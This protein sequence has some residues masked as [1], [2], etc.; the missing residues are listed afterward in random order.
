MRRVTTS[1]G[2]ARWVMTRTQH[3]GQRPA[4]AQSLHHASITRRHNM[5][6]KRNY[7]KH[8]SPSFDSLHEAV[9]S[10]NTMIMYISMF[11]LSARRAPW[12]QCASLHTYVLRAR[13]SGLLMR[14]G[15]EWLEGPPWGSTRQ[16]TH[17]TAKFRKLRDELQRNYDER[18]SGNKNIVLSFHVSVE[19][20]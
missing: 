10:L 13:L 16:D 11:T 8:S 1:L 7:L 20:I 18:A 12:A 14:G 15:R 5:E 9:W 19:L 4:R 6:Q 17:L 2:W 3:Q